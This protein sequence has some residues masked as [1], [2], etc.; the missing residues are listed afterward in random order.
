MRTQLRTA[1]APMPRCFRIRHPLVCFQIIRLAFGVNYELRQERL[2]T[3]WTAV[4]IRLSLLTGSVYSG[5]FATNITVSPISTARCSRKP[6][7]ATPPLFT[8]TW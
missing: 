6:V 5:G 8:A 3:P 1:H 7:I 2:Q 4:E